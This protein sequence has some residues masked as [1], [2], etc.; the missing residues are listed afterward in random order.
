MNPIRK[1][2]DSDF[3]QCEILHCTEGLST[4]RSVCIFAS[5]THSPRLPAY[6]FNWLE[7][8]SVAGIQIFFVST[9]AI[10]ESDLPKLRELT[11]MVMQRENKG[12]DF[13]SW[14]VV[15]RHFNGLLNPDVLYLC[16]DSVFG[17]FVPFSQLHNKFLKVK[18]PVMGMTDSFQGVAY[19][20]QS[21]FVGLKSIVLR[22]DAWKNFWSNLSLFSERQ[23]IIEQYEIGFSIALK[24]AGFDF[25]IFSSWSERFNYG[26]IVKKICQ[27]PALRTR[28]LNRILHYRDRF[29]VDINP[30]AFFWKELI[31][32]CSFPFLKRE[33]LIYPHL[34][35]EFDVENYW[36]H[37]INRLNGKPANTI[38]LF[39]VDYFLHRALPL[40][41]PQ[42]QNPR[43]AF[44][45]AIDQNDEFRSTLRKG[46]LINPLSLIRS[47]GS[48]EYI[49]NES[50]A[51]DEELCQLGVSFLPARVYFGEKDTSDFTFVYMTESV[52]GM[53]T[54]QIF[55]VRIQLKELQCPIIIVENDAVLAFVTNAL[56]LR[57]TGVLIE[58]EFFLPI[59][60]DKKLDIFS[61]LLNRANTKRTTPFCRPS[62]AAVILDAESDSNTTGILSRTQQLDNSTTIFSEEP[63][64]SFDEGER[65]ELIRQ[66]Y[67]NVYEIT[68]VWYKRFGHVLK[69]FTGA[70][71]LSISIK[72]KRSKPVYNQTVEDL[73]LWYDIQYESLP[74]WYKRFGLWLIKRKA[75]V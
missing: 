66:R 53:S 70:K 17:P 19:H 37:S 50:I 57:D 39:L 12:T 15:I 41:F 30:C 67:M 48:I 63:V 35:E 43:Y 16:N 7:N 5:H 20:I 22:S 10:S 1:F 74:G 14:C 25:Y 24:K 62:L 61:L 36:E 13:G 23:K 44:Y 55:Y 60:T 68:P 8:I 46:D 72:D 2:E 11:S 42:L 75:N 65:Y 26:R 28:W 29:F 32:E 34:F 45:R 58:R 69:L 9:V 38:R 49:T 54:A 71:K 27:S 31:E 52:L 3:G 33:L 6:V 40:L 73:S 47:L 51:E 56:Q 64:E 4:V 59:R 21:Y 18:E